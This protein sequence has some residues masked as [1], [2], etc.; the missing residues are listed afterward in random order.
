MSDGSHEAWRSLTAIERYYLR[1]HRQGGSMVFAAE[2]DFEGLV[3]AELLKRAY[4]FV[5]ERH[6]LLRSILN[7]TLKPYRWGDSMA[8]PDFRYIKVSRLQ[9]WWG[10]GIDDIELKKTPG[11]R[12]EL[13]HDM[14]QGSRVTWYTHHACADGQGS[15]RC[16]R[17][18]LVTY[19]AL[20]EGTVS[21]L[22]LDN[23]LLSQRNRFTTPAGEPPV[24]LSEGL[25]NL[26]FTVRGRTSR[27]SSKG[28][29]A[30]S[31]QP[32]DFTCEVDLEADLVESVRQCQ[33]ACK[34]ALNDLAIAATFLMLKESGCFD[35]RSKYLTV[36]NP[37]DLRDWKDRRLPAANRIGVAYLRKREADLQS[38]SVLLR[39]VVDQMTYVRKRGVAAEWIKGIEAVEG[40][41]GALGLIERLGM[42]IPTVT[43]TCLSNFSMGKRYGLMPEGEGWS[44]A[45]ARVRRLSCVAPLPPGVPIAMAVVNDGSAM[46][47]TFR[48]TSRYFAPA[49]VHAMMALWAEQLRQICK[50]FS[51]GSM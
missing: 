47:V 3:D 49:R 6:P 18:L 48:T 24:G 39:S 51:Q 12:L 45:G 43:V 32:T 27:A 2:V 42:F 7:T 11:V 16:F 31:G 44:L 37:V 10:Q 26:W 25:R 38:S 46:R 20:K 35:C 29:E 17:D 9:E 22:P 8:D 14:N 36:L 13:R 1:A 50:S 40:I 33:R 5:T 19:A 30:L 4:H 34:V 28:N 15:A 41:P 21:R 23:G